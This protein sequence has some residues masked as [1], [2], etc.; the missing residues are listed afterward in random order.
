MG[1]GAGGTVISGKRLLNL[2]K[3]PSTEK[4]ACRRS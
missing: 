4:T 1:G 2:F 3:L